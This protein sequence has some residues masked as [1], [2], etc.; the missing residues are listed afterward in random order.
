MS[1]NLEQAGI[2]ASLI[3][4]LVSLLGWAYT[5]GVKLG[6]IET[7]VTTMWEIYVKDALSEARKGVKHGNPKP[8]EIRELFNDEIQQAIRKLN[9][10]P[11]LKQH[12]L[13]IKIEKTVGNQLMKISTERNI[14]YRTILGA[15]LL[16]A[17][18]TIK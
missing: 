2:A 11:K 13:L 16:V 9:C 14:P 12:E 4:S 15:A 1:A 8:L 7:K 18:G 10:E 5:L 6:S 17:E 3:M